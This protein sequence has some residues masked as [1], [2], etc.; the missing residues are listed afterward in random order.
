[1][2]ERIASTEL[3]REVIKDTEANGL[4]RQFP[5][6]LLEKVDPHGWHILSLVFFGVNMEDTATPLHHLVAVFIKLKDTN[7]PFV[8]LV[9]VTDTRWQLVPTMNEWQKGMAAI[10]LSEEMERDVEDEAPAEPES[11]AEA[12]STEVA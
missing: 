4:G 8:G 5:A 9:N 3:L 7:V 11:D 10:V 12:E 2:S 6:D 1:M